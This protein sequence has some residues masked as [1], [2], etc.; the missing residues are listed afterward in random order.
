VGDFDNLPGSPWLWSI[1]TTVK[2]DTAFLL[3]G[4]AYWVS[5]TLWAKKT[6]RLD[7]KCIPEWFKQSLNYFD[8]WTLNPI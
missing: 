6:Y 2:P 3:F 7:R 1:A 4:G 8:Y 5:G